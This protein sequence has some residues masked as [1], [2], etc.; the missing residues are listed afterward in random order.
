MCPVR[1]STDTCKGR[2]ALTVPG[3]PE[4]RPPC[5]HLN[6]QSRCLGSG[7]QTP[8]LHASAGHRGLRGVRGAG[9]RVLLVPHRARDAALH[10]AAP[11]RRRRRRRGGRHAAPPGARR[12]RWPNHLAADGRESESGGTAH[13]T[14]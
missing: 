10:R 7:F 2:G 6:I 11:R 9:H 14:I 5:R 1:R 4:A 12:V 13:M 3:F 8:T